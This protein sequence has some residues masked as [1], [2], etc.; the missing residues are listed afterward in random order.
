M[1]DYL[2]QEICKLKKITFFPYQMGKFPKCKN[3]R[4]WQGCGEQMPLCIVVQLLG[5]QQC[6]KE[7]R[8]HGRVV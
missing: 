1:H 5:P 2:T 6:L 7:P 8:A 4:C 3:M